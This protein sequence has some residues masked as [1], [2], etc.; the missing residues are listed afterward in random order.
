MHEL[1]KDYYGRQLQSTA[2]LK[3][4][5]CCDSTQ[6]PAW[7]KPLLARIHPEVSARY[8]GCGLVCPPQLQG[9]RVLDLGCGAGRDVYALA[10]L[11]GEQGRVVGVDMTQEQLTIAARH[12]DYH[13]EAFGFAA[14]NVDF[15]QGYIERLDQIGLEGDSF[16]VIV[17]NCVVNL[18]PDKDAVLR[19]VFRLLKPGGEFYFSDIYADRRVPAELRNDPV[20]YG[21]CLGGALYW[22]DFLRVAQRHGFA[23]ARLVEDRPIAVTDPQLAARIGNIRFFSATYRLFKLDGLESACEDYGQAVIYRGTLPE[24]PHA[25]TLDKH[26]RLE[27]GRVFP[28]CGNTWRMLHGSRFHS[29]FEFIGDFSR[30][31]GLFEGCGGG[32]PFDRET[33]PSST[34][35][36]C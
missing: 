12:A 7:L 16:D 32:L 26:H 11:V 34:S 23:D 8:Y 21:E 28:V 22:N 18:S 36:C 24:L 20:L 25:F 6:T 33:N 15:R 35:A 27:T 29:H 9:C 13:R 19:E 17:S 31:Y 10:Q 14:G 30:H 2:D 3:T 4:S 5:A 1:V